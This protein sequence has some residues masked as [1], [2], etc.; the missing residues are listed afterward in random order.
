MPAPLPSLQFS[1]GLPVEI[2]LLVKEQIPISDLRTHVCF[3]NTCRTTASFYGTPEEQEPFWKR[4]CAW[5]GIGGLTNNETW[6][7]IAFECIT[8]DGFCNHPF[9]GGELLEWN[10]QQ[11]LQAVKKT[12]GWNPEEPL[13][14]KGLG[15]DEG[16][17]QDYGEDPECWAVPHRIIRYLGFSDP[18]SKESKDART[19]AFLRFPRGYSERRL[20]LYDHPI[21]RRSFVIFPSFSRISFR[22][23]YFPE[24]EVSN[25]RRYPRPIT[26][27]DWH[28]KLRSRMS[29]QVSCGMLL[30]LLTQV[31]YFLLDDPGKGRKVQSPIMEDHDKFEKLSVPIRDLEAYGTVRGFWSRCRFN[32]FLVS[33]RLEDRELYM[34]MDCLYSSLE[35]EVI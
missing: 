26:V 12:P 5:S 30:Y 9:C 4:V 24:S 11:I 6:K 20:A 2:L 34:N 33:A 27:W 7:E 23:F 13:S 8:K 16:S 21:A 3:Y 14:P 10:A 22:D 18:G 32:L 29:E 31:F 25:H 35:E 1:R 28:M 15:L 17:D 19:D